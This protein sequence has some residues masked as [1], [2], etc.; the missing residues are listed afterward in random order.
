MCP[1]DCTATETMIRKKIKLLERL[2]SLPLDLYSTTH[3]DDFPVNHQP[4]SILAS[5]RLTLNKRYEGRIATLG[6]SLLWHVPCKSSESTNIYDL[7]YK[8]N[9]TDGSDRK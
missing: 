3:G 4:L 8:R 6:S 5:L 7:P 1:G 2:F 9:L